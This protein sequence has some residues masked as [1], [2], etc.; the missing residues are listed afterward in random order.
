MAFNAS[1][2]GLTTIQQGSRGNVVLGWQQFLRLKKFPVGTPDGVFGRATDI[3][4]KAYQTQ[5]GLTADGIVGSRS[6]QVA[7]KQG[8]IYYL[9][10][11][12]VAQLLKGLNFGKDEI[13]DLQAALNTVLTVKPQPNYPTRPPLKVDGAFGVGSTLGMVEVYRQLGDGFQ[14]MLVKQLPTRTKTKLGE[15]FDPALTVLAEFSRRL[16]VRLSGP[17]WVSQFPFSDSLDDLG[18]PFRTYMKE[19]EAALK[20]AGAKIEISN[21]YRPPERAYIMHYCVR[22]ANRWNNAAD[23]PSFPGVDIDWV[24]YTNELSVWWA[25]KMAV[26]YDIAYPPALR[27]NHTIGRAID[28]YIEWEGTLKIKDLTGRIVEIGAPRNSF[29]NSDLWDVG[30]TYG[31]YKLPSDPPHWSVDGF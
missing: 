9:P 19:F 18:F 20:A 26:A 7:L 2:L 22:I 23:V 29:D 12:T 27:S 5:N 31:V 14:P 11:L 6:F 4:T 17:E 16:R 28:W 13:Q 10:D 15:D 1:V 3:A 30:A 24:H 21:T 25:D 8:F